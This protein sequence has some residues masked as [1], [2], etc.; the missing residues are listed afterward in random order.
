VLLIA[1]SS[2]ALRKEFKN[3]NLH[4]AHDGDTRTRAAM[5][6]DE[7]KEVPCRIITLPPGTLFFLQK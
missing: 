1:A 2:A 6:L 4:D 7:I 3:S 5:L